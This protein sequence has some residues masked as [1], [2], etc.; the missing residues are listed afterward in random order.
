M[1]AMGPPNEV[2]PRRRATQKISI[3]GPRSGMKVAGAEPAWWSFGLLSSVTVV[4]W[5]CIAGQYRATIPG[6]QRTNRNPPS[7]EQATR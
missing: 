4:P 3:S 6:I 7:D 1:W 5:S 2:S